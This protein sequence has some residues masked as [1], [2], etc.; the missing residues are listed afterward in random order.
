MAL[1]PHRIDKLGVAAIWLGLLVNGKTFRV[2]P[3]T[4]HYG[5]EGQKLLKEKNLNNCMTIKTKIIQ[6]DLTK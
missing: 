1:R 5:N 4:I 6:H 2:F 3:F